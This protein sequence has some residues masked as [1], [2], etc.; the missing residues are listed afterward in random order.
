MRTSS[1]GRDTF[2]HFNKP[3]CTKSY[4]CWFLADSGDFFF[5]V[6]GRGTLFKTTPQ[7][8]HFRPLYSDRVTITHNFYNHKKRVIYLGECTH[9]HTDT[10]NESINIKLTHVGI[11][12]RNPLRAIALG[13]QKH[14]V[15]LRLYCALR[16]LHGYLLATHQELY[17]NNIR[18]REN[19]KCSKQIA[20]DKIING[21]F[22][23]KL[24]YQSIFRSHSLSNELS[25]AQLIS[26]RET[27]IK[28]Y[29][30]PDD[31]TSKCVFI[32]SPFRSY[33]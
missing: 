15:S 27:R 4:R 18:S 7:S 11:R 19:I 22:V 33:P 13:G 30:I 8:L 5:V 12:I 29:K 17:T 26:F 20:M 14:F 25:F 10:H 6:R 23:S 24:Q 3:L 1:A 32:Y 28:K 16:R 31:H 9:T 2:H 21:M